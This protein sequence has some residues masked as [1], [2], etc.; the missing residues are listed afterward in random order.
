MCAVKERINGCCFSDE[1]S[2]VALYLGRPCD[3][4]VDGERFFN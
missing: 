1:V 3:E 2:A 4:V